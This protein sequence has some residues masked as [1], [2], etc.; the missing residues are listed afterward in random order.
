M[1]YKFKEILASSVLT[2]EACRVLLT[3]QKGDKSLIVNPKLFDQF[4]S[5]QR[6][7][8]QKAK[9]RMPSMAAAGCFFT[10]QAL[11]QASSEP[12]ARW[13]AARMDGRLLFDLCGG[14]GSDCLYMAAG[15]AEVV[16]CDPDG[17][18]GDLFA[19]N[20][21]R[22]GIN[23]VRRLC[24]RAEDFLKETTSVA[25]WV[26]LD[27]DRR[28][29]GRRHAGFR[30]Y[31]PEPESLF[32]QFAQYGKHWLIKLSPLDDLQ[33]IY[34]AFPE[35]HRLWVLSFQGEVKELLVELHPA[36]APLAPELH[37]V[38]LDEHG[39]TSHLQAPLLPWPRAPLPAAEGKFLYEPT[40]GL[41][42]SEMLLRQA[43][44]DWVSGNIRGTLWFA[45][46]ADP[47]YPGRWTEVEFL[48]TN[49][50]LSKASRQLREGGISA[51]TVKVRELPMRSEEARK[52]LQMEEGDR[53]RIY[54]SQA[55]NT[56]WLAAGKAL[57]S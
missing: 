20:A 9:K 36:A 11:E 7:L 42:K 8:Y 44:E 27:P 50:S 25:D 33:A 46:A 6:E 45:P 43:P 17:E 5:A 38:E 2:Q 31:A 55:G 29:D 35:L 32:R 30:H 15:F 40:P 26:Y 57:R 51:A 16:S 3:G 49:T 53:Y 28:S 13:K 34:Q 21:A 18:L 52:V 12:L 22:L 47:Q 1:V 19:H 4:V 37:V 14:L 54:L 39:E 41:I 10:R 48:L 56:R 24:V 23:H